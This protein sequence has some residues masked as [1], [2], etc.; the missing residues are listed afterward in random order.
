MSVICA[1]SWTEASLFAVQASD[2]QWAG[3]ARVNKLEVDSKLCVLK[4]AKS[5]S[6]QSNS[7][8]SW[9]H[10]IGFVKIPVKNHRK[11]GVC[12]LLQQLV[13]LLPCLVAIYH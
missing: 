8:Y 3:I 10:Y 13:K 9:L 2:A 11:K 5:L 7:V 12:K 1:V 4:K 6:M